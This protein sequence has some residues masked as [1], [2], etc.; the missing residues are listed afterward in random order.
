MCTVF[1]DENEFEDQVVANLRNNGWGAMPVLKYKTEEEL[2]ENWAEILFKNNNQIDRLNGH[3]LTKG[4]MEQIINKI[5]ELK[6][7]FK[8][9]EF[10]N[11]TISIKRD[12][13]EDQEHLGKEISLKLYDRQEIAGGQTTYQ[14]ARQ[15]NYNGVI[16]NFERDRRGDIMLLINGMPLINIELKKSDVSVYEACSQIKNYSNENIFTG[17]FSLVQIFVAM[18]PK[19]TLYFANP[20]QDGIFNTRFFF[21]WAD[22]NNNQINDWKVII[23]TLLSIPM[24]HKL[25]GFYTI[26]DKSEGFLKVMRSYQIYAASK[27]SDMVSKNKDWSPANRLGGYIWHTTGSGK[28]MTSFK[29]AQLIASSGD[30]DKV[31]FL[32]DRIEL[33]NQSFENYTSFATDSETVQ[34]TRNSFDLS[35]KLKSDDKKE[36]VLIVSSIQKMSKISKDGAIGPND[37]EKIRKK[38]IVFIIDECHRST[39]GDMLAD[40]KNTFPNAMFFGFTGT[41]IHNENQKKENTT[42]DVFGN[43]LHR[44]SITNGISDKNVLGF[45]LNR[46]ETFNSEDLREKVALNEAGVS[47]VEEA[48]VDPKS[49]K[50]KVFNHFMN[51]SEVEMAG[52]YVDGKYIKGIEDYI[53]N[54]QYGYQTDHPKA[55]VKDIIK[56]WTIFSQYD[57]YH[58]IFATSCIPE[59]IDYY[60]LFKEMAPNLKVTALFDINTS[61]K[62][63]IDSD[64]GFKTYRGEAIGIFKT[65]AIIEIITDYANRFNN[66]GILVKRTSEEGDKSNQNYD[67]K[68]S[69]DKFK[70]DLTSRLAHKNSYK[71]LSK[72]ECIDIVIV[73]DQ[74]LTGFDSKWINTMYLDKVEKYE[75]IIQTFSRTNRLNEDDKPCGIIRYYRKPY[76]MEKNIEDA[77]KLYSGDKV[78]GLFIDKLEQN[79]KKL[80]ELYEEISEVFKNAGILDFSCNPQDDAS[81]T[82]FIKLF[83]QF[84]STFETAK[85]QGFTFE[86]DTYE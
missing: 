14:I 58:A 44:Y 50:A 40:I 17:L 60:R 84:K 15:P 33:G 18:T 72:E 77:V 64:G 5:N 79:V 52:R 3:K 27:I 31:I 47:S 71:H 34:S 54:S 57:K 37:L 7:P 65:K 11:G 66:S 56:K 6:T 63:G 32:V 51:N 53:P 2:I 67:L 20:G 59:A 16:S 75:N 19:E 48:L 9:N 8:L 78:Y 42:T 23:S 30:A 13:E 21:H 69:Y 10:I 41:P 76:T 85:I 43:E 36:D 70:R 61:N 45:D 81:R 62:E 26:A 4:E 24:A 55:V 46:V 49:H 1:V 74:L 28:T 68:R 38:K 73:V 22:F 25:I 80:N 35:K 12:C 86:Q 29:S 83:A 39:F 82:K